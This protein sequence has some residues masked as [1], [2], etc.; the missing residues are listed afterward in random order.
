ME[1]GEFDATSAPAVVGAG[2]RSTSTALTGSAIAGYALLAAF[3]RPLTLPAAAAILLP[4]GALLWWGLRRTTDRAVRVGWPTVLTWIALGL[5][6]CGWELV[7]FYSG[8]DPAHPTFSI[9]TDP[10]FATYPGRVAGYSL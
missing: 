7:A 5:L 6:F 10:I 2:W 9:L 3:A 8:N 1:P 4:G